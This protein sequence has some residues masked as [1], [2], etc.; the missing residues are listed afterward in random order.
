MIVLFFF[1]G[2]LAVYFEFLGLLSPTMIF[3]PLMISL[4]WA[5]KRENTNK[6]F[7]KY[8][9]DITFVS[10][11]EFDVSRAASNTE[12]VLVAQQHAHSLVHLNHPPLFIGRQIP[13]SQRVVKTSRHQCLP[14]NHKH[15][16]TLA[17][18]FQTLQTPP[19]PQ[20]PYL[21]FSSAKREADTKERNG[22]CA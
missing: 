7:I 9:I 11:E 22:K 10:L 6:P 8:I 21:P 18:A 20:I 14:T 17:V 19:G 12:K 15:R 2:S 5:H 4:N 16:Y 1:F 3:H 13:G